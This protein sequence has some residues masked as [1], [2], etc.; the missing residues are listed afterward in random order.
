MEKYLL[1]TKFNKEKSEQLK[2]AAEAVSLTLTEVQEFFDDGNEELRSLSIQ[3]VPSVIAVHEMP[4]GKKVL[5]NQTDNPYALATFNTD[6]QAAID[7]LS[8]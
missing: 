4:D 8:E 2:T 7:A 3:K 1:L 6:A 5:V